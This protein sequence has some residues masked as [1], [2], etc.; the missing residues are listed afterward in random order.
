MNFISPSSLTDRLI[1][2]WYCVTMDNFYSSPDLFDLLV[3]HKT[4]PVALL[5]ATDFYSSPDLF[6][7]LIQQ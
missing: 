4:M 1:G 2:K 6:D 7:L 5:E 3:Q